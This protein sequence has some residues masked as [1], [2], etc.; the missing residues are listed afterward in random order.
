MPP[1]VVLLTLALLPGCTRG[2]ALTRPSAADSA[3]PAEATKEILDPRFVAELRKVFA[4]YKAWGRVDDELRWAP[5]LCRLP[6][7]GKPRM[8][9]AAADS[10]HAKKLYSLFAREHADYVAL[11]TDPAHVAKGEQAVVKESYIPELV[12]DGSAPSQLFGGPSTPGDDHFSPYLTQDG[13]VYRASKIAGLYVILELPPTTPGTDE[14]FVYGTLSPDGEVTS[15][16]RVASCMGCH[17]AAKHRRLFGPL[18]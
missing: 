8:S 7:P 3:P 2:E 18:R 9:A 17:L 16:G 6:E 10:G 11:A 15:A 14:G 12:T 13:K 1:R 5:F 4:G